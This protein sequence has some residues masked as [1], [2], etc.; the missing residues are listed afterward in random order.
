MYPARIYTAF[1]LWLTL[2]AATA[3]SDLTLR[4]IEPA[5]WER[6]SKGLDYSKDIPKK[7]PPPTESTEPSGADWTQQT[8]MLG[9]LLQILAIAAAVALLGYGIFRMLNAPQNK[10]ITRTGEVITLENLEQH[11]DE[12]DIDPFL[13]AALKA[14]NYALAVRLYYLQIIKNLAAGRLLR[15]SKEKTNRDYLH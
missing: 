9:T 4:R 12:T 15:W 11:L 13:Q 2:G 14:Q 5:D 3:Q 8:E 6:A 1:L 7:S 10:Q